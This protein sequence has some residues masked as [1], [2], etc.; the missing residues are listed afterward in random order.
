[1]LI[2]SWHRHFFDQSVYSAVQTTIRSWR[3]KDIKGKIMSPQRIS[4]F[5]I[6]PHRWAAASRSHQ[7][8]GTQL[9]NSALMRLKHYKV[10]LSSGTSS[11]FL[12]WSISLCSGHNGLCT[13]CSWHAS[14]SAHTT[15]IPLPE[16]RND[17]RGR[18]KESSGP[19]AR[20]V[21]AGA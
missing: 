4:C 8:A 11:C 18:G 19:F 6:P 1:M 13:F 10:C 7:I 3:P 17:E 12:H 5:L 21:V 20:S 16:V 9:S 15:S 2:A 14:G